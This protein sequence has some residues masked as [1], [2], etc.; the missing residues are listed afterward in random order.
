MTDR[1]LRASGPMVELVLSARPEEVSRARRA[2]GEIA[3]AAN[4]DE[5]LRAGMALAVSEA[6]ANVVVHAYVGSE[7]GELHV[8]AEAIGKRIVITVG[9]RGRGMCPRSDSPGIGLGLP[10][11]ASLCSTLEVREREGGGTEICM[12][13]EPEAAETRS[14]W[15]RTG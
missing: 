9:D 4:L 12:V 5:D 2:V 14:D 7:P 11:M 1:S 6:C 10:L 13:F 15:A 3:E 8:R